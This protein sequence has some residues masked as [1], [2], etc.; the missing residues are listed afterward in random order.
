MVIILS[1]TYNSSLLAADPICTWMA[2]ELVMVCVINEL[3]GYD[4]WYCHT[5]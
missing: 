5:K 4:Q 2:A 1:D 3:A